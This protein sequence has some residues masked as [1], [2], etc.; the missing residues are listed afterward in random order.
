[1]KHAGQW[2]RRVQQ[3]LQVRRVVEMRRGATIY[4]QERSPCQ[5]ADEH[6]GKDVADEY[7]HGNP[8]DSRTD[9]QKEHMTEDVLQ[10]VD[11]SH[12]GHVAKGLAQ[13]GMIRGRPAKQTDGCFLDDGEGF[14]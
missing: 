8:Q 4:C 13:S 9:Q 14:V 1:M 7:S 2:R 10:T 6:E 12:R 5:H 11:E 3:V